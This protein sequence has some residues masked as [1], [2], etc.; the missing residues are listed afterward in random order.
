LLDGYDVFF[1]ANERKNSVSE[2]ELP[3][4]LVPGVSD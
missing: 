3:M 2:A 1:I 4:T